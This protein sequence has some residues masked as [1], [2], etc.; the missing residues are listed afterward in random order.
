MIAQKKPATALLTPVTVAADDFQQ[1]VFY[2]QQNSLS[3]TI[4]QLLA[5]LVFGLESEHLT[6]PE[7][8]T[9]LDY[10]DGLLRLRIDLKQSKGVSRGCR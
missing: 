6:P 7:R 2:I 8:A 4:D 1:E 9:V 3:S 10:I 5:G